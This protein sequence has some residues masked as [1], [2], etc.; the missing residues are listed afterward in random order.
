MTALTYAG[1]GAR[2][3]PGAVLAD[4]EKMAGWL[5]RNCGTLYA[6]QAS[7][8]AHACMSTLPLSYSASSNPMTSITS[9]FLTS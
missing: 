3:T 7:E 9:D 6:E 5:A 4:M 1:I 8:C 2:A